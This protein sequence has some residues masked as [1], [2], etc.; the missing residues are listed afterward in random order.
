VIIIVC[1]SLPLR[2]AALP[3][4]MPLDVAMDAGLPDNPVL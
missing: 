4:G 2:H 3:R 1:V